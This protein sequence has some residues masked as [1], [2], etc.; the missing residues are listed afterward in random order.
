MRWKTSIVNFYLIILVIGFM[1][2]SL[3]GS[4]IDKNFNNLVLELF[5][6]GLLGFLATVFI[7]AT[8]HIRTDDRGIEYKSLWIKEFLNWNEIE[9]YQIVL[10]TMQLKPKRSQVHV[11]IPIIW[12]RDKDFL[13]NLIKSKISN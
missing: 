10:G 3:I 9:S 12:V 4:I 11:D 5:L 6:Y 2:A 1:L 7:A 8:T 13:I